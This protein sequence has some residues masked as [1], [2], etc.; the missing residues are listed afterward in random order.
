MPYVYLL[1]PAEFI[2]TNCYK[3]GMSSTE[4]LD[5]LRSY[6][7]NTDYI[8]FFKCS[9]AK[10]AEKELI[11]RL[12]QNENVQLFKGR[13]Y[14]C[15]N[16]KNIRKV[17]FEVMNKYTEME[18]GSNNEENE[19]EE[20][21]VEES[22]DNNQIIKEAAVVNFK[23][24]SNKT[25]KCDICRFQCKYKSDFNRHVSSLKHKENLSNNNLCIFCF[26][27]LSNKFSKN[28]HENSCN[29]NPL[30]IKI[31]SN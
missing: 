6:R 16:I 5:R 26:K 22:K 9:N 21:N 28:R 23:S 15:S 18:P 19:D 10:E 31:N 11:D 12:N 14:F 25:T 4:N 17:F 30:N 7:S 1:Q 29:Q 3:I 2:N 24:T 20:K 8:N 13:E 27:E